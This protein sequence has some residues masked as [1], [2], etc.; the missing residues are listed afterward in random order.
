MT[1][2][3]EVFLTQV[4]SSSV[5]GFDAAVDFATFAA[6]VSPAE[7]V[8]HGHFGALGVPTLGASTVCPA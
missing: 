2:L 7:A 4:E 1:H 6:A 5:C 8:R 3:L